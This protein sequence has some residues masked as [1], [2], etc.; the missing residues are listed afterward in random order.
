MALAK[1]PIKASDRRWFRAHAEDGLDS[2]IGPAILSRVSQRFVFTYSE[3]Y[4]D[5]AGRLL[6]V[7]NLGIVSN[8]LHTS[9]I[10]GRRKI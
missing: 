7:V 8:A 1:P 5:A 10:D 2:F 4:R 6:A 9:G 3:S